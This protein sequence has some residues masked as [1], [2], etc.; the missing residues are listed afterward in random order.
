[1]FIPLKSL[2]Q[3]LIDINNKNSLHHILDYKIWFHA[4]NQSKITRIG[5]KVLNLG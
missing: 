4:Q 1:M 2:F 5:F 3:V